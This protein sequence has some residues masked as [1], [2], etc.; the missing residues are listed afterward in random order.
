MATEII[1]RQLLIF[2]IVIGIGAL[3][4]WQKIISP[5]IKNNLAKVVI[6]ITLPFLIFTTFA[7]MEAD[8]SVLKNGLLVFALT[9][10]NLFV[11]YLVGNLSSRL[12][13]LKKPQQTVHTLHTMF[14][15][16]VFLGFPLL[17]ALFPNGIGIF[18]GAMYQLASNTI[19]FTYG[20]YKLSAGTQKSGIKSLIN[21]NTI[22]LFLGAIV[23]LLPIKLPSF[24][25][26]SL[27]SIGQCTSP[28]SMIYIGAMLASMGIKSA[29]KQKSIYLLSLNKLLIVPLALA[30][31]YQLAINALGINLSEEAFFVII[32]Q[33]AMPCQTIIVVLSQRYKGDY[34]L[35]GANLFVTTLLSIATL[36]VVFFLVGLIRQAL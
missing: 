10:V 36:P 35:A 12:L 5:E 27:S 2:G 23:L 18:Y 11:F 31:I 21:L 14:G 30:A 6:D 20:V 9:F 25:N 26:V 29:I 24:L 8:A 4:Y 13:K 19:T 34:I 22:A 32:L 7:N 33:A 28:L 16:I 1:V 15:N 17:D 3:A